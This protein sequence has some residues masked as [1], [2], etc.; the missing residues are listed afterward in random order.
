[1]AFLAFCRRNLPLAFR[2]CTNSCWLWLMQPKNIVEATKWMCQ[3]TYRQIQYIHRHNLSTP[4]LLQ[5]DSPAKLQCGLLDYYAHTVGH[6]MQT[7]A[8][9]YVHRNWNHPPHFQF[10][11][12]AFIAG[13]YIDYSKQFSYW[14]AL[15]WDGE[16]DFILVARTKLFVT[17][18]ENCCAF[19]YDMAVAAT[20]TSSSTTT[21]D[22][23][24]KHV[25]L[26]SQQP[27]NCRQFFYLATI[28]S[29]ENALIFVS[30]TKK[31]T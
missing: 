25:L 7:Y 13:I 12:S 15:C 10:N 29:I 8:N 17:S 19:P 24:I 21:T 5:C 11:F 16:I 20:T 30:S 14:R 18:T 26:R 4:R 27:N 28:L 22:K 9:I 31:W 23:I 1:M 2:R 3:C 6:I